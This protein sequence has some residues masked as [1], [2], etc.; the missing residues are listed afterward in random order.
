MSEV[1]PAPEGPICRN[2]YAT[3]THGLCV[4]CTY[5]RISSNGEDDA[6]QHAVILR[7]SSEYKLPTGCTHQ[8]RGVFGID[9][10]AQVLQDAGLADVHGEALEGDAQRLM[11]LLEA[12]QPLHLPRRR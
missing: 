11:N 5:M 4:R 2:R 7:S 12:R 10:A 8:R 3:Q 9:G 6:S 1:L